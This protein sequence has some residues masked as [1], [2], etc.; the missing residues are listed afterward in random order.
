MTDPDSGDDLPPLA[1]ESGPA[2][3]DPR[4][5]PIELTTR[6]GGDL[7]LDISS[8]VHEAGAFTTLA[9]VAPINGTL[10]V[11]GVVVTYTPNPGFFGVDGFTLRVCDPS[12]VCLDISASITVPPINDFLLTTGAALAEFFSAGHWT[13]GIDDEVGLL[14]GTTQR[15]V[16]PLAGL[17]ALVGASMW[18]G[19]DSVGSVLRR[20]LA[21]LAAKL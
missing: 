3:Q 10:S 12:A 11:T 1:L 2:Q 8:F 13:P 14:P 16:V 19:L 17:A 20:W 4:E 9:H 15:V 21:M 5:V 6:P 7:T 18:F